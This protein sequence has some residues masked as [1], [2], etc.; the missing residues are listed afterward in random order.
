MS[1][2]ARHGM[3]LHVK[4]RY[5]LKV[6]SAA[7]WVVVL[8]VTYACS[9]DNPPGLARTIK[10]WFANGQSASTLYI[11][12]VVIYLAP[13]MLAA[14]LFT[15]P[16][17]RRHLERS[18]NKIMML[19]MWWSQV[20]WNIMLWFYLYCPERLFSYLTYVLMAASALCWKR[21]AWKCIFTFEVS[22]IS[23]NCL[24]QINSSDNIFF[25]Y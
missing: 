18:N 8:P 15:V 14:L 16:L 11:L 6:V 21:N 12:A 23:F 7:A 5:I 13:N 24:R 22:L 1:W 4:L 17:L 10:S 25:S 20:N 3:S 9:W 19:M 2:R